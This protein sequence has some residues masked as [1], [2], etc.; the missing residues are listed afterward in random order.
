MIGLLMS[1]A[2][3]QWIVRI[4]L[5]IWAAVM[6]VIGASLMVDHWIALPKPEVDDQNWSVQLASNRTE[7][8]KH[9]WSAF[10][11]LYG[12]CRCS[13]RV[14]AS[15]LK[16]APHASVAERIVLIGQDT[17][18]AL[19]AA[20]QGYE[21]DCVTPEELQSKYGVESAPMFVVL[22]PTGTPRYSGGYTSRKQ[23]FDVRHSEVIAKIVAGERVE[24]MPVYGCA[25]SESLKSIVDP[26]KLKYN[27]Q[28]PPSQRLPAKNAQ[29][30]AGQ[31]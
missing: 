6:V 5:S 7:S 26:L 14:L 31:L 23:G 12:E 11:F 22:D 13:R 2:K 27:Y 10:H 30:Y 21:F 25:V 15:V 24:Q 29:E 4:A 19:E 17:Q 8:G 3:P 20:R 18:V 1:M 9:R 28:N 16:S